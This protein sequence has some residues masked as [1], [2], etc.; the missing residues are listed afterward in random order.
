MSTIMRMTVMASL[1]L[2]MSAFA[3]DQ[4]VDSPENLLANPSFEQAGGKNPRG[5]HVQA[6]EPTYITDGVEGE[7]VR[8]GKAAIRLANPTDLH[9][10]WVANNNTRP[11]VEGGQ[12]YTFSVWVKVENLEEGEYIQL[13]FEMFDAD[14][15]MLP[16]GGGSA[17]VAGERHRPANGEW[18]QVSDTLTTNPDARMVRPLLVLASNRENSS[19]IAT[20]DDASLVQL[21]IE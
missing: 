20:F 3:E 9:Q 7:T 1:L 16:P 12:A 13:R 21:P 2:A 8:T 6:A 15:Q 18:V 17:W 4:S 14:G 10:R 5:W 11:A 19:A